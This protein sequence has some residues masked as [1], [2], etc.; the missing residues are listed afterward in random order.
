[1]GEPNAGNL[2]GQSFPRSR[3]AVRTGGDD[4]RPRFRLVF[5]TPCAV[6]LRFGRHF[7]HDLTRF[8]VFADPLKDGVTE[9][10][11]GSPGGKRNFGHQAG[12]TQ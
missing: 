9:Q 3:R 7:A 5:R 11:I 6:V 2:V 4:L 12:L 1:M 8:L 10:S